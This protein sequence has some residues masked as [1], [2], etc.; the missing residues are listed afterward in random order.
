MLC[1]RVGWGVRAA[2][3]PN[4]CSLC[5]QRTLGLGG[6]HGQHLRDTGLVGREGPETNTTP[7]H[8]VIWGAAD[9][10]TRVSQLPA[11][12]SDQELSLVAQPS[13]GH[14]GSATS[15]VPPLSGILLDRMG[16]PISLQRGGLSRADQG[17]ECFLEKAQLD[18]S[19]EG[20]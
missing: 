2:S 14:R 12:A 13:G 17:R 19:P 16:I 7:G 11:R 18:F 6:E 20:G 15:C 1:P 4:C 3:S 9:T 10:G 8:L 5:L